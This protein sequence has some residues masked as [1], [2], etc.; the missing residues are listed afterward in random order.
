MSTIASQKNVASKSLLKFPYPVLN[1][2]RDFKTILNILTEKE[3]E[4]AKKMK[5]T[6]ISYKKSEDEKR[7]EKLKVLYK[8]I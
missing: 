3:N 1:D 4:L 5:H 2:K 7:K 6:K 8:N